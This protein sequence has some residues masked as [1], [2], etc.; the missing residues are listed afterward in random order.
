MSDHSD[1]LLTRF[2]TLG[3]QG[4]VVSIAYGECGN[5]GLLYSINV[6]TPSGDSFDKPY[7]ANSFEQAIDIAEAEIKERGWMP[8]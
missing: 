1:D 4:F 2:E 6:L 5:S 3:K 7:G 8:H